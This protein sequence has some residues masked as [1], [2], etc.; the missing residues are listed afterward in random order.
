LAAGEPVNS[1]TITADYR[2]RI[3]KF[4]P[5]NWNYLSIILLTKNNYNKIKKY[6]FIIALQQR[7][8]TQAIKKV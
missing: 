2:L 1:V 7:R 4:N 3:N 5:I 8:I 6:A